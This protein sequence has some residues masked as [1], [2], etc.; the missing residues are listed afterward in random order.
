MSDSNVVDFTGMTK[1]DIPVDRVLENSKGELQGVVLMGYD[2]NGD[3]DFAS[4]YADQAKV[5]LLIERC[6][7]ILL[8]Q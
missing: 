4:N 7:Q 6:K 8:T 1:L 5:L 2:N 3:V